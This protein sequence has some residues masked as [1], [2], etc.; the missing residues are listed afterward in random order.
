M[1][2]RAAIPPLS[3][4]ASLILGF[5]VSTGT[6]SAAPSELFFSEYIEGSSNNKALEIFNGTGVA[7]DLAAG[8]YVVQMF[9]NGSTTPSLT[10]TLTGTVA[11]GD[12]FVLA[13]NSANATIL[14]QADQTSGASFYNGDDAIILRKGGAGGAIVDSIGQ[15]GV[16]P[17]T[18]WGTGLTSTADNTLRRKTTVSPGDIT[19]NDAFD[20]ATEWDGFANDTFDGLGSYT[21]GNGGGTGGACNDS[22][23]PIYAI[24]GSGPMAAITGT[25]S[26]QGV[27]V[28]DYEGAAPALRGFYIQDTVG[29]GNAA[30][31]DGIFVFNADANSIN[32]GHVVRVTGTASEIQN[33]TQISATNIAVCG[34]A[35]MTPV[36]VN[37]PFSST[38]FLERY[39]GMLVRLPQTLYVT[40]H[41]QLGRFGQLVMSS[42]KRLAQPTNVAQ[43]GAAA[44]AL[45]AA[46]DLNR[47]IID[48]ELNNQN[49]DPIRFGRGG[50]PLSASNTLRGGDTATGIVGVMTYTWG[51]NSASGNAYRVRPFNRLATNVTNFNASNARPVATPSVGGSIKVGSFNVLNYFLTLDNGAANCGP[52]SNKQTCRGAQ[53]TVELQRQQ[54]KL[55]PAIVKLDVDI[56]GLVELENSHNTSGVDVKPQADIVDRLNTVLGSAVYGY[57]DSGIIGTD[58]IRVGLIYK[59]GKVRP[60]GAFSILDSADDTRFI[61]TKNRPVLAQTFEE[62][63][64]GAK[65]T[66]AVNHLKSKGSACTDVGDADAGD[67]QGNCNGT[68]TQATAALIDWLAGDPT[69]SGD[70]DYLIIGDLNSYAKE[71]PITTLLNAGY[72]NLL[73][74]FIGADA[75]GYVFNGQWGYLDHALA[76]PTLLAQVTGAM[77]YHINADEPSALDYNTNFKSAGQLTSLYAA[78]EYP[79]SDHDPL[80]IG[81]NL[82]LPAPNGINGTAARD[83]LI[84]TNGNDAITGFAGRDTLTGGAGRDQFIYTSMLDASDTITDFQPGQDRIVLT[85]LLQSLGGSSPHPLADGFVTCSPSGS[86]SIIN[87]DPDGGTGAAPARALVLIKGVGCSSLASND[88]FTF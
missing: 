84:G 23:T 70:P 29:D 77:E 27:V 33:Q 2:T 85:R 28:G 5:I 21:T 59:P 80:V 19:A 49:P 61:D 47:I 55:I 65:F 25:V 64:T 22:F 87:I 7:V 10:L 11:N 35:S 8:N 83:T 36:D 68:R 18:E 9:F 42:Q 54:N 71:A 46:N 15:I 66:V 69:G 37:L 3:V 6:V 58:A 51:G 4:I 17:G 32:V 53:T 81:L 60:V 52:A 79:T 34:T 63:A 74:S 30:T 14:A 50:N 43:P 40:E 75:Y 48:D 31:S 78:D 44:L 39:E 38:D 12:V 88:N 73:D 26:T 57:V 16:D 41:F 45:Q 82:T 72:T 86:G 20:P 67:G 1:S 76:S 62:V 24:Q 56:L 13:Q